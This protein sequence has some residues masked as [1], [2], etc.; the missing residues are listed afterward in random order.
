[1]DGAGADSRVRIGWAYGVPPAGSANS[2]RARHFIHRLAPKGFP[3]ATGL[4]DK[5]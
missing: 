2:A 1:M 4:G 3:V 5:S